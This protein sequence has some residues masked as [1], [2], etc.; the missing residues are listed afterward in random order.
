VAM[1]KILHWKQIIHRDL[2]HVNL[3]MNEGLWAVHRALRFGENC[4]K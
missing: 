2:N 1:M 3:F 4:W